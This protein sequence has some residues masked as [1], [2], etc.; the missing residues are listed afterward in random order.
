VVLTEPGGRLRALEPDDPAAEGLVEAAEA[1]ISA[2]QRGS[3]AAE[4]R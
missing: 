2:A 1:V 4:R 3:A